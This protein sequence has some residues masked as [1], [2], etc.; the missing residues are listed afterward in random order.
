M[1]DYLDEI[2]E[3]SFEDSF[4]SPTPPKPAMSRSSSSVKDLKDELSQ[5]LQAKFGGHINNICFDDLH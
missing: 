2:M 1:A 3:V 5:V 4:G